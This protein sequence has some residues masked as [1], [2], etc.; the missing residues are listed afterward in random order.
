MSI[1]TEPRLAFEPMLLAVLQAILD[2]F[3]PQG[4]YP[5]ID[6][7]LNLITGVD[8]VPPASSQQDFR[9]RNVIFPWIQGRGLEALAGH[10]SWLPHCSA[11]SPA[12]ARTLQQRIRSQSR[13]VL[14][15]MEKLRARNHGYLPF[16]MTP[17]GRPIDVAPDGSSRLLP[18]ID[19]NA[20]TTFSD[21]FYAK[22]L[23]AAGRLLNDSA[24]MNQAKGLFR[25][26][27]S[28]IQ[29]QQFRSGQISFD[30]KNRVIHAP[31]K[32]A[33]GPHMIAIGGLAL[34]TEIFPEPNEW[35]SIGNKF[36]SHILNQHVNHGQWPDLPDAILLESITAATG[37]PWE[38]KNG[39]LLCD[40]GHSLE[41][42]GLTTKFVVAA[43]R[44]G[45]SVPLDDWLPSLEKVF[46]TALHYGWNQKTGGIYK[47]I[48]ARTGVPLNSDMPWWPL[49]ETI[50]AA[51]GL[52]VLQTLS[53][54]T[55]VERKN[56][57]PHLPNIVHKCA[58]TFLT[59]FVNPRVHAMAYQTLSADGIPVPTIPATP[60]ADPG[61]HTGLSLIDHLNW[62]QEESYDCP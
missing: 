3:D 27:L 4:H 55:C 40:P 48:D 20:P 47:T 29:T 49:P 19:E 15:R 62:T 56:A 61:Y 10:F 12:D 59:R 35:A 34:F 52:S 17:D 31:E 42:V 57:A 22:G 23:A 41:F 53:S 43:H 13:A 60:D 30:P 21:L 37:A 50:R 7:K 54:K 46:H 16:M 8:F 45:I 26:V 44:A 38:E 58:V 1:P 36:I 14:D 24:A 2:R 39:S 32:Q 6:T 18:P 25:R 11:L 51:T 33:H 5:F 28:D 9:S